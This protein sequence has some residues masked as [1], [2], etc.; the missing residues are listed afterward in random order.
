M[1]WYKEIA[2]NTL[3]QIIA[4]IASSGTSFLITILVAHHFGIIGYGDFAKVTGFVTL[5]YLFADFGLNAVFLQKAD[6]KIRF[7]DLFYTRLLWSIVL[8]FLVT[9]IAAF[10]PYNP[11]THIGFSPEV[12]LGISIFSFTLITEAILYTS[13][14]IFQRELSYENFMISSVI[15][16][17]F[18]LVI[19]FVASTISQSL[20][21]VYISFIIG[22]LLESVLALFL[23]KEAVVPFAIDLK[24]VRE[25]TVETLPIALLLIFNL[26][27]FRIDIFLL[28][29]LKS[30]QDVGIYDLAYKFFDFLIALPL[31]LSNALYP[32]LIQNEKDNKMFSAVVHKYM[33][34]FLLFSFVVLIP[35]WIFAPLIRF[36]PSENPGEFLPAV[37]PLRLLALSLPVFFVTNILQWILV[38]KKQ[39]RFLAIRQNMFLL[40]LMALRVVA[41]GLSIHHE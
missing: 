3:F 31:F 10:L 27:Y 6:A 26:I 16:S 24:F 18:T 35:T 13:T 11:Q 30:S 37:L 20:F 5:F 15:G 36:I 39:Q 21:A 40:T 17:L 7:K 12:R 23:T 1:S 25:L 9:S 22:G 14:A 38:A 29:L 28:S 8:T 4:R 2:T 33:G 34:L 32:S 19:V 41:V